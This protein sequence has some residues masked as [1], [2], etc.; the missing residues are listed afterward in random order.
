VRRLERLAKRIDAVVRSTEVA[1]D[2][3]HATLQSHGARV[4]AL[5]AASRE[6]RR[7]I[8]ALER[9]DEG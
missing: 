8:R 5:V 6:V 1:S 2:E 9:T 7:A 3:T 4:L